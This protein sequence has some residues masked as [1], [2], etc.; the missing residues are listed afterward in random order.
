MPRFSYIVRDSNGS[1]EAGSEDALSQDELVARLQ[2]RNL[3]VVN[4]FPEGQTA[5]DKAG[6]L[7]SVKSKI[8][9]RHYRVTADD[10]VMF[11][12]QLATL[13]G[14]GVNI[15]RSLNIISQ[16][17][18]SR[19]LYDVIKKVEKDMEAGLS[20]HEAIAKHPQVFS[21]LWVNLVE[22]GEA[23]GSLAM[24][25]SRLASYLE[26]NAAFTRKIISALIY[27]AIL[28]SAG[29]IALLVM[30]IKI[31]P[32]FAEIFK[33][34]N[35][36]LPALTQILIAVSAFLREKSLILIIAIAAGIYLFKQS[37]KSGPGRRSFEA[38][39][40]GLPVFGEFY[41][42]VSFERFSSEISTLLESGV[43][44]L[45]CLEIADRSTGNLIL[46]DIIRKV[47]EDVR[48]GK[49]L[50]ES[51]KA[52]NF[53]DPM[54]TQMVSIGEEIGELPQMFKKINAYYQ[55]YTETF[56]ARLVSLF[57]PVI[58][59]FIGGLIGVMV[60]GMFLPI[61]QIA[62]LGK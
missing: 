29:I 59:V 56:L 32:T 38:F 37:V 62:N 45:Y 57:E 26:K 27:P 10:L 50:G 21:E 13:L 36:T 39:K 6:I 54:C 20:L 5:A 14:A 4:V 61:F 31:I 28:L 55:E 3:I 23:S 12:R 40:F 24:V 49:T 48:S 16:Q 42:S 44:I 30:A 51:F 34:F 18:N 15:L 25:L 9:R 19:R 53:F 47:K 60:V 2:A 35:I 43:P 1:K 52:S 58:L 46:S 7:L 17:V 22:S 33:G 11:S 8:K 41:R